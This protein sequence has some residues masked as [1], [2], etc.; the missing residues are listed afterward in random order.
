M[1][2]LK[3]NWIITA[4][5]DHQKQKSLLFIILDAVTNN[6]IGAIRVGNITEAHSRVEIGGTWIC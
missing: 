3:K 6:V 2:Q 5:T 1:K 4:I